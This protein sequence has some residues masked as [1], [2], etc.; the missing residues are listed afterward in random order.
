VAYYGIDRSI[1]Y[2]RTDSEG[3][4]AFQ[5]LAALARN[6]H[7]IVNIGHNSHRKNLPTLL[8]AMACLK[9]E[10]ALP[11][12][13]AKVGGN[14]RADGYGPLIDELG[15]T[16][17]VV[18]LGSLTPNQVAQVCSLGHVLSFP[19]I[20]EGFGRPTIEAQAC[21]LPCV[22]GNSSCMAEIGGAG[23]L[24]HVALSPE[25][26]AKQLELALTDQKVRDELIAKGFVNVER[27]TWEAHVQS[28]VA[29]YSSLSGGK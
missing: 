13:L 23:A 22:L 29:I 24:Y 10:R 9:R 19:S 26:L 25:D 18:E 2:R 1:F 14:L 20:Y 27:F 12:K 15:L 11:V 7:I 28:L 8:Q 4:S 3:A 21:G 17:D 6:H 5:K 16:D